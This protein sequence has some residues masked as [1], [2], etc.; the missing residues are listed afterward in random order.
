MFS[1]IRTMLVVLAMLAGAPY[2]ATNTEFGRD[3]VSKISSSIGSADGMSG[4]SYASGETQDHAHHEVEQLRRQDTER[5]RYGLAAASR[6]GAV[7]QDPTQAPTLV[8]GQVE[9]IREVLRFD[10]TPEWVTD[11]FYRVGTVLGDLRLEGLRVP[12]VTGTQPHD[13]A[14]TLTYYF[15]QSRKLQRV[16]IHGFTGDPRP[17]VGAMT[18]FYGLRSEPALEAG[19]YTRRWNGQPIH[20]LRLTRAPVVYADAVHQKYTVF[21]ELNQADLSYGISQEA[22]QIVRSDRGS[23]RW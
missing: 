11:R 12:V 6:M 1:R 4:T 20:F 13:V 14:G 21:L 7:P 5:Y 16:T 17:L 15:D 9:D 8:G 22:M 10:I 3:A 23:G 19:V 2:V 18:E